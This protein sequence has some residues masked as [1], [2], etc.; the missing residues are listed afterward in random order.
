MTYWTDDHI[1]AYLDGELDLRQGQALHRD[2][3]RDK[4]LDDYIRSMEIDTAKLAEVNDEFPPRVPEFAFEKNA[5]QTPRWKQAAMAAGVLAVFGIGF[6][7][8]RFLPADNPP[9]TSWLQAAA[10]YQM[11]YS[12]ET[13]DLLEKSDDQRSL[14]VAKIGRKLDIILA[15]SDI[16]VEGLSYKRAQLLTFKNQP[17]VQ[18]SYLDDKNTP[19]AFC[20]FRHRK[21]QGKKPDKELANVNLVA[22]QK[23]VTWSKG[24]FRFVVIGKVQ[25]DDLNRYARHLQKRMS[26]L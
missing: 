21:G 2:R 20:I 15:R 26:N 1:I 8:S 14:E 4:E 17:L 18:F 22:G 19:I 24:E 11:L 5:N 12:G 23:A 7:T 3:Q 25:V 10:E 16:D 6:L 13:L 9:P